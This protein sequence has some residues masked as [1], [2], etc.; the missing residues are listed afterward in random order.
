MQGRDPEPTGVGAVP[1]V[2][3]VEVRRPGRRTLLGL[4]P[5][6]L[7]LVGGV[8]VDH[9]VKP[10]R[11]PGEGDRVMLGGQ[12]QE[13]LL[14]PLALGGVNGRG[15]PVD[16]PD[17]DPRLVGVHAAVGQ[18]LTRAGTLGLQPERKPHVG[19]GESPRAPGGVSEPGSGGGGRSLGGDVAAVRGSDHPEPEL[20]KPALGPRQGHQR[21]PLFRRRHRPGRGV[22]Q[23]VQ[24]LVQPRAEGGDRVRLRRQLR[25]GHASSVAES[26]PLCRTEFRR[27]GQPSRREPC[28]CDLARQTGLASTSR[29]RSANADSARPVTSAASS[30]VP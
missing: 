29:S 18:R 21:V 3:E 24:D 25:R 19:H 28:G 7:G 4:E 27:G 15:Q 14:G 20:G 16:R 1:V 11:Q 17:D 2:R 6:P 30:R 26:G 12:V 23:R 13:V 10:T 22:R 5:P 8:R 9:L